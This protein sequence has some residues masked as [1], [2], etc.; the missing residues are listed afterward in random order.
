MAPDRQAAN[1]PGFEFKR[2][3]AWFALYMAQTGSTMCAFFFYNIKIMLVPML[4]GG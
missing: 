2:A 1:S 4:I 3:F